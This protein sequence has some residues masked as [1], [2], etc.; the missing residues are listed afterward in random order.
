MRTA[1]GLAAVAT[2]AA[3]AALGTQTAVAQTAIPSEPANAVNL[4][5]GLEGVFGTHAARRSGARGVC[6]AGEFVGNKAG[7]AVSKASVFSGKPVPVI[8][9]FSVGGGNPNAPE[10]GKGVRGLAAQFDLPNGEQWLMANISAPFFTAATPDGFLAFLEA[11]KPDPATK[12]PDPAKIAAAAAKYPDFKPQMEWVAKT[13]VP[14]SYA[15]V[16]YWSTHAFKF[17]NAAGKT[18]FAKWMFVPVTG[19]EFIADDKLATHAKVFLEDELK[20]RVSQI[21]VEFD[22]VLQLAQAGDPTDNATVAWPDDRKKVVAGRLKVSAVTDKAACDG[23]N[24][25][26]LVLPTGIEGSDDPLLAAR[27][28]SYAVSQAR[29]LAK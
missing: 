11:R 13:G 6:A 8:L 14:A 25:N 9:R 16:N 17:T 1:H 3:L 27:A 22:M 15:A 28:G 12:K 5:D 10:S 26:P 18:Q 29:R 2:M 21:P 19:Q 24:F 4:V 20:G 23:I 7:A